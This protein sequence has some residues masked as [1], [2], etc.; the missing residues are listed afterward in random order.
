[1]KT[2]RIL[3][4]AG[5]N[6]DRK[7]R[8][9]NSNMDGFSLLSPT[10]LALNLCKDAPY[11]VDMG[12]DL[13]RDMLNENSI[14]SITDADFWNYPFPKDSETLSKL[15][16]FFE[17]T[18]HHENAKQLNL[19][20]RE[21]LISFIIKSKPGNN[22]I[23]Y[24]RTLSSE[25]FKSSGSIIKLVTSAAE[26]GQTHFIKDLFEKEVDPKILSEGIVS[27][28]KSGAVETLEFLL[29]H[30]PLG[31]EHVLSRLNSAWMAVAVCQ[32]IEIMRTLIDWGVDVNSVAEIQADFLPSGTRIDSEILGK[33]TALT[34]SVMRGKYGTIKFLSEI[35]GVDFNHQ[36][37]AHSL[38]QLAVKHF[39]DNVQDLALALQL[40][41]KNGVK[42][43]ATTQDVPALLMDV[44]SSRFSYQWSAPY[45]CR[46][47]E[48]LIE[49]GCNVDAVDDEG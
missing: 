43:T 30:C 38:I 15:T 28:A 45:A 40:L 32:N 3:L 46:I 10:S 23:L 35:P 27:A 26:F 37:L 20:S 41:L 22:E 12:I 47:L 18:L 36:D 1:M 19:Q 42:P 44:V 49:G 25:A 21:R 6:P 16:S 9:Q 48:T 11:L 2:A 31:D 33:C 5:A 34:A 7:S 8:F 14:S 13:F 4:Q 24:N 29:Q 17:W 39:G